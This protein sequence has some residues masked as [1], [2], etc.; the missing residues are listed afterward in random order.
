MLEIKNLNICWKIQGPSMSH[1]WIPF[2]KMSRTLFVFLL[3]H[4]RHC[5]FPWTG[6]NQDANCVW[7]FVIEMHL[8][9]EKTNTQIKGLNRCLLRWLET[10]TL[11]LVDIKSGPVGPGYTD[12]SALLWA[13]AALDSTIFPWRTF[14]NSRCCNFNAE[15]LCEWMV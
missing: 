8:A 4:N 9:V 15:R 14:N 1:V 10:F 2:T 6:R 5:R 7:W 13:V 11:A 3:H 12:K